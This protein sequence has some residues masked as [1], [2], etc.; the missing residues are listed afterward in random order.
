M[1]QLSQ[2][3]WKVPTAA[4]AV[5][6]LLLA[7]LFADAEIAQGAWRFYVALA[8]SAGLLAALAFGLVGVLRLDPLHRLAAGAASLFLALMALLSFC[9]L[10][11]RP[12]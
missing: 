3:A 12:N 7:G 8:G 1:S 10:L 4:W 5:M 6:M 2:I 11:T 9:D